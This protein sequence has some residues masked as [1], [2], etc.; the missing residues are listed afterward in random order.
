MSSNGSPLHATEIG[1]KRNRKAAEPQHLSSFFLSSPEEVMNP[2][3]INSLTS[4]SQSMNDQ[5]INIFNLAGAIAM[6]S[7]LAINQP[8][9]IGGFLTNE[10]LDIQNPLL[11]NAAKMVLSMN[12]LNTSGLNA[13]RPS[14]SSSTTELLSLITSHSDAVAH[15]ASNLQQAVLFQKYAALNRG[16]LPNLNHHLTALQ[17]PLARTAENAC[18]QQNDR[19]RSFPSTEIPSQVEELRKRV[20]SDTKALNAHRMTGQVSMPHVP[21]S[22]DDMERCLNR[23]LNE[24]IYN[25]Y[26]DDIKPEQKTDLVANLSPED[27]EKQTR[28]NSGSSCSIIEQDLSIDEI[29]SIIATGSLEKKENGIASVGSAFRK[30]S[31]RSHTTES[32]LEVV[33][34]SVLWAT[35]ESPTSI[36]PQDSELEFMPLSQ[37][38]INQLHD[39]AISHREADPSILN[40]DVV[41]TREDQIKRFPVV[42]QGTLAMK[43]SETTVQMHLVYGSIEMLTRCL[44]DANADAKNAVPIRVNQRMR[45]EHAQV[46][47]AGMVAKMSDAGRFACM[48]CLPCGLSRD[49][50]ITNSD[51]F[52]T[53][54]I[55]YFSSKQAAGIAV[56]PQTET[57]AGCLVHVFP[58]G[59]FP[60]SYLQYYSPQLY[61]SITSRQASFLFVVLT[62]DESSRPLTS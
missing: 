13:E 36:S 18:S 33:S 54:F 16:Q 44:G 35:P 4:D 31:S 62:P 29:L 60:S 15:S 8:P 41:L 11:A 58:P 2:S 22:K 7:L 9:A 24:E 61:E 30:V 46:Q 14:G 1:V 23:I 55:D 59:D 21:V 6:N 5:T 39:L 3:S 20:Y 10:Q 28:R 32:V 42:W 56:M 34:D 25:I 17:L 53:A 26:E 51:I 12:L 37:E 38:L 43:Q 57:T 45:L 19:K 40:S 48:I 27:N 49:E 47:V 52:R 50:I